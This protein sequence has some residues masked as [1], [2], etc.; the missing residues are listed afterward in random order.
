MKRVKYDDKIL[1]D[2]AFMLVGTL[3]IAL[4]FN[5]CY[6]ENNLVISGVSGLSII[7]NQISNIEPSI[8]IAIANLFLIILSIVALGIKSSLRTIIGTIFYTAFVYLTRD[9]N[10]FLNIYFDE[11][12]MYLLVGGLCTGLGAGLLFKHGYSSGGTDILTMVMAKYSKR[13]LGKSQLIINSIIVVCGGLVFGATM[14]IYA[15]L[16]NYIESIVIDKVQL[17]F[18]SSKMFYIGTDKADEMIDFITRDLKTGVTLLESKGGYSRK[19]GNL[20]M[21]TVSSKRYIDLKQNIKRIDKDAFIV[22]SEC[23]EVFGGKR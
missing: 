8:F 20:I 10:L 9:I 19:K 1:L 14:I 16:V 18:S 17:G 4:T 2:F 13:E 22:V 3:L 15:I 5:I 12:F 23:Y 7:V 21:C 11:I 6:L